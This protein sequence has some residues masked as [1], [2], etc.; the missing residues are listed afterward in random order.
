MRWDRTVQ[1]LREGYPWA[2][3]VR[4]G[5]VAVR[6]RLFGRPAVVV[7]GPLGVRR[8]YDP[9]LRRRGGLPAAIKLVL[10][11]RARCLPWTTPSTAG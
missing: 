3:S 2:G 4:G 10:S 6:T 8:F 5:A 7:G 9:R 11:A 1:L